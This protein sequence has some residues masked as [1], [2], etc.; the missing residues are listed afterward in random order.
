M[1]GKQ[2]WLCWPSLTVAWVPLPYQSNIFQLSK[3]LILIPTQLKC[4][5]HSIPRCHQHQKKKLYNLK[6]VSSGFWT[7]QVSCVQMIIQISL[8]FNLGFSSRLRPL[9][10]L[11]VRK[12]MFLLWN[13][14]ICSFS[15][16]LTVKEWLKVKQPP[17]TTTV[18]ALTTSVIPLLNLMHWI[19]VKT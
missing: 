12:K 4:Y 15:S 19:C 16:S 9:A 10:G 7:L 6:S 5:F 3:S 8:D 14:W 1:L 11:F 2:C 17:E 18:C 13:Q